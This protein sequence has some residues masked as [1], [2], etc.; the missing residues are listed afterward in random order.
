MNT[1]TKHALQ[2]ASL[3]IHDSP[4]DILS[5]EKALC[6]KKQPWLTD[7]YFWHDKPHRVAGQMIDEIRALRKYIL[8]NL[9]PQNK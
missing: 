3:R 6:G 7:G 2:I 4:L 1:D 5:V 8:N 9:T